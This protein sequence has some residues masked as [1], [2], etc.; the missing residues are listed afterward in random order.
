MALRGWGVAAP[1][2]EPEEG[3]AAWKHTWWPHLWCWGWPGEDAARGLWD[4]P[5]L[6]PLWLG[7][8]GILQ[9]TTWPSLG[10]PGPSLGRADRAELSQPPP[11]GFLSAIGVENNLLGPC[12]PR[13]R[14]RLRQEVCT[15]KAGREDTP[16]WR[17]TFL[18]A[19]GSLKTLFTKMNLQVLH[20]GQFTPSR[21]RRS[22]VDPS[23]AAAPPPLAPGLGAFPQGSRHRERFRARA[24]RLEF[25]PRLCHSHHGTWGKSLDQSVPR[26]SSL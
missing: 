3:A 21:N 17:W 12:S 24:S 22:P 19:V 4:L 2:A 13:G 14:V 7:S 11:P 16:S 1:K 23:S 18:S 15:H 25:Q 8:P 10:P 26:F 5:F 6:Q 20:L 9:S